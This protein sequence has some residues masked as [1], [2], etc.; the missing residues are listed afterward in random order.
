M[1]IVV[2]SLYEFVQLKFLLCPGRLFKCV[3]CPTAYHQGD[4]C[5]AAGS[6]YLG[7]SYIICSNHFQP[8]KGLS[9]HSQVNINWCFIC[10]K[11][12]V[13]VETKLECICFITQM[14]PLNKNVMFVCDIDVIL[15]LNFIIFISN[16]EGKEHK[17]VMLCMNLVPY[18]PCHMKTR[19]ILMIQVKETSKCFL[20]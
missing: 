5:I 18:A 19:N 8:K 20:Y 6:E 4:F 10:S 1:Q 15:S 16:M 2:Y 12:I 14:L 11:G 17:S 3:K 9:M 7:G 13:I